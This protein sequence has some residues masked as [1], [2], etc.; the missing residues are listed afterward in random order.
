MHAAIGDLSTG[1]LLHTK[2]AD[3]TVPI[4]SVTKLMTAMV[5]LDSGQSL[6]EPI[7]ILGW[8]KK[9]AKKVQTTTASPKYMCRSMA[10]PA[11]PST[12]MRR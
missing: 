3:R 1:K 12:L 6:K 10:R 5:V 11:N 8:E 2:N 7:T 9:T 4:A